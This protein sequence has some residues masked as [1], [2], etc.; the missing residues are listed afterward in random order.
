[1]A[2]RV[3]VTVGGTLPSG[4]VDAV[5]TQRSG[6]YA[7]TKEDVEALLRQ[8]R[9]RRIPLLY[10]I[11]DDLLVQHPSAK[12]DFDLESIRPRVRVLARE[13]DLVLVST[14][15]L[16]SRMR[17]LNPHVVV[18]PNALDERL[19]EPL[20][21]ESEDA[22]LFGYFGTFSHLQDLMKVVQPIEVALAQLA[23]RP[24]VELCGISEDARVGQLFANHADMKTLP[25]DADYYRF[26]RERQRQL[27]WRVGIAPLAE[28]SFN[29][30]KS[31]MKI[32]DYAAFGIP[33][34]CT[35]CTSYKTAR[36]GQIAL[37]V[38]NERFGEALLELLDNHELRRRL[39]EDARDWLM[40][41]RV[42]DCCL[43]ALWHTLEMALD[44]GRPARFQ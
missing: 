38:P 8:V 19:I 15:V 26:M 7:A 12:I 22:P 5:I 39:R 29:Q 17:A 1:M 34:I 33:I 21:E 10:D 25:V 36:D 32:L 27:R 18:W 24:R 41:T 28:N 9:R 35:D 4:R 42:L 2:D 37:K 13:A 20:I 43:P 44:G 14:E 16:A 11:D 6:P 23:F 3:E 30:A 31:D 40:Q